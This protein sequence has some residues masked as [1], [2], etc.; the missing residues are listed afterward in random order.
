[1]NDKRD[2]RGSIAPTPSTCSQHV[3]AGK[4][5]LLRGTPKQTF[6]VPFLL[7][8]VMV[9]AQHSTAQHST[10]Q[11][12][13]CTQRTHGQLVGLHAPACSSRQGPGAVYSCVPENTA[14]CML[15]LLLLQASCSTGSLLLR[16]RPAH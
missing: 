2:C 7:S 12:S 3:A 15:L 13:T 4:R 1:V 9:V 5:L 11:H 10:A 8:G 14:V 6:L 16:C